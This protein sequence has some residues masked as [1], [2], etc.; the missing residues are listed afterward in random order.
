MSHDGQVVI[1]GV[2]LDFLHFLDGKLYIGNATYVLRL[3]ADI[4]FADFRHHWRI[5]RQ[6]MLYADREIPPHRE[7]V[8]DEGVLSK[9]YGVAVVD[10]RDRQLDHASVGL[11]F[12]VAPDR[13]SHFGWTV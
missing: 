5:G 6:I 4:E 13:D 9:F 12:L 7:Y 10:N 11:H 3:T 8:G 2:R 1:V